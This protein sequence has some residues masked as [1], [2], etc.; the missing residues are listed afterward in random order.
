MALS[1]GCSGEP[2]KA[3][4]QNCVIEGA[5]EE[6]HH[7]WDGLAGLVSKDEEKKCHL[8]KLQSS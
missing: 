1:Y 8:R 4:E 3:F 6:N 2:L 5:P 7:G